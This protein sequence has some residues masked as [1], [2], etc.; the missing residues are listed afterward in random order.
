MRLLAILGLVVM[1]MTAFAADPPVKDAK[2]TV[3][4]V[5]QGFA[6]GRGA[7]REAKMM[8]LEKRL[9]ALPGIEASVTEDGGFEPTGIY[10]TYITFDPQKADLGDFAK[11]IAAGGPKPMLHLFPDKELTAADLAR[12]RAAMAKVKG[13]G[14]ASCLWGGHNLLIAIKPGGGAKLEEVLASL[15][16]AGAPAGTSRKEK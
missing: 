6:P 4:F 3:T 8:Q 1:P 16:T 2:V 9:T 15:K 13:G 7:A 10:R 14:D 12:I 5:L 11:A